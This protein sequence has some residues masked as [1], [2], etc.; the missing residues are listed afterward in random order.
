[1]I[2]L[3]D[4][5]GRQRFT[6]TTGHFT[7]HIWPLNP[8]NLILW[9][10]VS[11]GRCWTYCNTEAKMST[12]PT[13]H[14]IHPSLCSSICIPVHPSISLTIH[15]YSTVRPSIHPSTCPYCSVSLPPCTM[16]YT[17]QRRSAV[18]QS[19]FWLTCG[20]LHPTLHW[21]TFHLL[22]SHPII[23]QSHHVLETF[24]QQ[25]GNS[26]EVRP[27]ITAADKS[28]ALEKRKWWQRL[29]CHNHKNTAKKKKKKKYTNKSGFPIRP[30][31]TYLFI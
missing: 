24:L 20:W 12:P 13:C 18:N 8:A 27:G 17:G 25:S 11:R 16:S 19:C 14:P 5:V 31:V 29:Y 22:H 21:R 28:P 26:D 4:S 3:T 2:E 7:I 30:T 6:S 10:L 9:S 1:M 15:Q 23:L